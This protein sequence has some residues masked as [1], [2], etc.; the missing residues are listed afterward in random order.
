MAVAFGLAIL[1]WVAFGVALAVF[2]RRRGH[3]LFPWLLPGVV[4]G[5]LLLPYARGRLRNE[6]PT[7]VQVLGEGG[8]RGGTIDVLVGID[9]S[10]ES[11]AAMRDAL[12]ILGTRVG[13]FTLATVVDYET[14]APDRELRSDRSWHD[15]R[16]GLAADLATLA[17]MVPS[18]HAGTIFLTGQPARALAEYAHRNGYELIVVGPRGKGLSHVVLGSVAS[19]LARGAK[20]PILI[21]GH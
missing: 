3:D 2:M 14:A 17:A 8:D 9:G 19:D 10:P 1:A 4:F 18:A 21:A 7:G 12:H 11:R 6:R 16:V 20:V 13:R 5:P 15:P